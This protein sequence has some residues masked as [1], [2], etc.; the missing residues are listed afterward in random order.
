MEGFVARQP[1]GVEDSPLLQVL[2]DVRLGECGVGTKVPAHSCR[3]V[4]GQDRIQFKVGIIYV[5]SGRRV[6]KSRSSSTCPAWSSSSVRSKVWRRS[7]DGPRLAGS[8]AGAASSLRAGVIGRPSISRGL[9]G[10]CALVVP[11]R[12]RLETAYSRLWGLDLRKSSSSMLWSRCRASWGGCSAF[13]S[14]AV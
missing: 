1:Y 10:A 9:Y 5:R 2:I 14:R 7:F 3:P 12:D 4:A 8:S 6:G 13:T 11:R